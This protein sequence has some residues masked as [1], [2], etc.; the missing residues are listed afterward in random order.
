MY[1]SSCGQKFEKS[2][3]HCAK[4]GNPIGESITTEGSPTSLTTAQI[5]AEVEPKSSAESTNQS[6]P[7]AIVDLR[8]DGI[9]G[10]LKFYCIASLIYGPGRL[11][12]GLTD[13]WNKM[14]STATLVLVTMFSVYIIVTIANLWRKTKYG[15]FQIR[16]FLW[17]QIAY[18]VLSYA[19]NAAIG[20]TIAATDVGKAIGAG[21]S[22]VIWLSYFYFSKRVSITYRQANMKR[23]LR[24]WVLPIIGTILYLAIDFSTAF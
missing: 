3:S 21:I 15:L 22:G 23:T 7:I 11:F 10:W 16:Y 13:S 18:L 4:C 2:D 1:C 8:L 14:P 19:I 9:H 17:M 20:T 5:G 24:A 12:Q 6:I